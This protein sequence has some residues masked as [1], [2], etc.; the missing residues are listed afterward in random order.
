MSNKC[1]IPDALLAELQ[2]KFHVKTQGMNPTQVMD[3]QLGV[4]A[5]MEKKLPGITE[6]FKTFL[7]S[8]TKHL[9]PTADEMKRFDTLLDK[10]LNGSM[11]SNQMKG[12]IIIKIINC[13]N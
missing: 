5:S 1:N 9:L 10:T 8:S 12:Y 7:E 11:E 4:L 3:Y 2:T 13:T 6:Q